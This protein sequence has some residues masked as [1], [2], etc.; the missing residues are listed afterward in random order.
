VDTRLPDPREGDAYEDA[1]ADAV[2]RHVR[3][4]DGHAFVLFTSYQSLER[5][6]SAVVNAMRSSGYVVLKQ[7]D[8][9]PRGRMLD[10]FRRAHSAVLFGTDTFW[11][12]VDV[13]GDAL[14]NVII[15]R[16]PFAVP[17]HPVQEARTQAIKERGG[18][19]FQEY[20]L[21]QAILKLKQGFGRLIRTATD[22]GMVVVL[23][24]RLV[25]MRYGKRFLSALPDVP[26]EIE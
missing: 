11:Q 2:L 24:K 25:T 26:L 14:R 10:E 8:G 1:L 13:P 15:A 22:T 4:T 12:G 20:S 7:G 23:D 6:H 21:P 18:D 17:T 3:R 16:L 5:C 19:P 9:L